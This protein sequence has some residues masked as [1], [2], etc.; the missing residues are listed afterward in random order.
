MI[1]YEKDESQK[2][3]VINIFL[4]LFSSGSRIKA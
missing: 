1:K 2:A 4:N 3:L